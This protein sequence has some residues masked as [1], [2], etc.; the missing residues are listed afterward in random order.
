ME[1]RQ[2]LQ[3][4]PL[5]GVQRAD[6][7]LGPLEAGMRRFGIESL[8]CQAHYLA[9]LLHESQ[10]FAVMAENLNYS[11]AGLQATFNPP[12]HIRFS[13][14]DAEKYGRTAAHPAN[15][16]MIAM[17]AYNGRMGNRIDSEDGYR[18][19]GRGPIQITG[20]D[21]YLKCST[22]IGVDLLASP[23]LLQEPETGC[24][25]A[26]WF[27]AKGNPTGKSL[28]TLAELGDVGAIT[29]AIN[30]GNKGLLERSNLTQRALKTLGVEA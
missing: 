23:E 6:I 8:K 5:M 22:A 16:R 30:G 19:R 29:R 24:L 20:H 28:N 18:Y 13:D 25:A 26:A 7:F 15:Q 21:N 2:L 11:P 27:W 12:G 9:Q 3:I 10:N 17:V 1:R 14:E 4:A